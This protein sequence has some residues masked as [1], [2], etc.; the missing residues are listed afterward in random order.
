MSYG[1]VS[2]TWD[3]CCGLPRKIQAPIFT[4][5]TPRLVCSVCGSWCYRPDSPE[6]ERR[7]RATKPGWYDNLWSPA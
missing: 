7:S 4:N 1:M 2:P 3:D 5:G 6:P